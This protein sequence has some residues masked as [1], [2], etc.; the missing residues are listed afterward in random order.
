MSPS[1]ELVVRPVAVVFD[2]DGTLCDVRQIRH[3]VDQP[4]QGTAGPDFARFHSASIGCPPYTDVVSLLRRVRSAG[5]LV[6]IVTGREAS[7]SFLT[8]SWLADHRIDYDEMFMRPRYDYRAD[9]RVKAEIA[10]SI[11]RK[12]NVVLAVDDRDDILSV[13]SSVS[14]A[15]AKVNAEGALG[16]VEWPTNL[17]DPVIDRLVLRA[18]L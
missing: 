7:W 14:V 2:V 15:T 16:E 9:A 17:R 10:E 12:Y 13:W 1:A 3:Y 8:S 4:T 18:R 6:I 5:Y 11:L